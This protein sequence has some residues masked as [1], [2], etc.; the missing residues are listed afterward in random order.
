MSHAIDR[1]KLV[2]LFLR[3]KG[4]AIYTQTNQGNKT[5]HSEPHKFAYDPERA[6]ELLDGLG[7]I[8]RDGDGVREDAD[9]NPV[10][11]NLMTNVENPLRVSIITQI[12]EDWAA[13]GVDGRIAPVNFQELVSQLMDGHKWDSILLGWG[14]AV[15]PDPLNG[16]NILLPSGRLHVWHPQQETPANE[17]EARTEE[18]I[19]AMDQEPDEAERKAIYEQY[20][21]HESAEQPIIYLFSANAYSA[22]QKRVR[23]VRPTMLR[24]QAWHNVEELW[25]DTVR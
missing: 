9:G 21:L 2:R 3:G 13:V 6:R 17:F 5:W 24:P 7:L 10:G 23:N 19:L 8:D 11:F 16:K 18:L 15:P 20:I 1:D 12:R 25:L 22:A 14:A 4:E